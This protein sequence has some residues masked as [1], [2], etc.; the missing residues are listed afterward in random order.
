M[1]NIFVKMR[2]KY[3]IGDYYMKKIFKISFENKLSVIL[4]AIKQRS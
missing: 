4:L 3:S 1:K 2:K